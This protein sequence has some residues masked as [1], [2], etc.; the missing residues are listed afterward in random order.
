MA[1]I[2]EKPQS[3]D[4]PVKGEWYEEISEIM[5]EEDAQYMIWEYLRDDDPE[6]ADETDPLCI[7]PNDYEGFFERESGLIERSENP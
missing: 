1:L 6:V 5:T 4:I 3:F 2:Q 7:D